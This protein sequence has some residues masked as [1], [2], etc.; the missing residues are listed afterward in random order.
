MPEAPPTV[1]LVMRVDFG[2]LP[3]TC[4]AVAN[5]L[6]AE[7]VQVT[8]FISDFQKVT[9]SGLCPIGDAVGALAVATAAL[10]SLRVFLGTTTT[11]SQSPEYHY[12]GYDE[13]SVTFNCL[14]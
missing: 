3:T 14:P 7:P 9:V 12:A 1:S 2:E 8:N 13:Y 6:S 11:L 4:T 5:A 10:G